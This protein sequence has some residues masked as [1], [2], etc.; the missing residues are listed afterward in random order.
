MNTRV[1]RTEL[2]R[3]VAPW[4]GAVIL[5]AGVGFFYALDGPWW[6]G[7]SQ[8]TVQWTSLALWTRG[9]LVFLWPVAVGLGALQGLR[10]HRSKV[11]ELLTSTPRPAWH[12]AAMLSGT[13]A[14]TLGTGFWLFVLVGAVQV[15][16]N[17]EYTHLGWLPI[18]LVAALALVAGAV[19][20]MGVGRA[21]PSALTPPVLAVAALFV[22][23]LLRMTLD[24]GVPS[25]PSMATP[26]VLLSPAVEEVTE[27]LLTLSASVH[28][29][30]TVWLL[31]M[32]A[33][34]FALLV[35]GTRRAKALAVTPLLSGAVVALLILPSSPKQT[36]VVAEDAAAK[37]CD[38]PVCVAKAH[39]GELPRLA[40]PGK[41][42]LRM[43]HRAMGADAPT[44]V[45]ETTALRSPM[46]HMERS[47][48]HV[49]VDFDD[50]VL[51]EAK[52]DEELT[53]VLVG[54]GAAPNCY[55]RS[56]AEGNTSTEL[57]AQ[58]VAAGWVLG[59]LRPIETT[60]AVEDP[61][62]DARPAWKKLKALPQAEQRSRIDAMR[63]SSLACD[64]D[65]LAALTGGGTK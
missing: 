22:T 32:A 41:K 19:L 62:K 45:R 56:W 48:K 13:T 16:G 38:G 3:S 7:T 37:V 11:P 46:D 20:G 18:S 28:I 27:V 9:L 26:L 50:Q 33:T 15:L 4:A 5:L 12:R 23:T 40:G 58:T 49:T 64:N 57:A 2:K 25:S 39:Q 51:I 60:W 43:L 61:M 63:A 47:R 52:G 17:A 6:K 44:A 54:M 1:L 36:Y 14:L 55:A 35:A 59:D 53:R 34:G 65:P 31:G 24:G 21:L 42:A 10:D 30:Q 8:W 29:G